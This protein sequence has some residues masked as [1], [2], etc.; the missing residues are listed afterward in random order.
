MRCRSCS[1]AHRSLLARPDMRAGKVVRADRDRAAP[2]LTRKMRDVLMAKW[3]KQ[4]RRCTYC[5][6]SCESIDHVIPLARGGTN[7]E[8]NL[9]PCCLSCNGS[10]CASL[11]VE[12]R[13]RREPRG[14]DEA[15]AA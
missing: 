13:F 5:G 2:G 11:L 8:G 4:G 10:K 15:R 3:R 7:Y 12:W 14:R 6:G 1:G 9:V